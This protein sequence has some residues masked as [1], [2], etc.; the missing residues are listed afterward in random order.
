[1]ASKVRRQREKSR[2]DETYPTGGFHVQKEQMTER[3]REERANRHKDERK[4][5]KK[6]SLATLDV[7][8]IFDANRARARV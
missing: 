3:P 8:A 4:G 1:L 6:T 2:R 7:E 5:G